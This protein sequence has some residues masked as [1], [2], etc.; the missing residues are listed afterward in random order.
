MT[1]AQPGA[2]ARELGEDAIIEIFSTLGSGAPV[3]PEVL[4][5]NGDDAA[6]WAVATGEAVVATTDTLVEGV[7]F[8][9][10]FSAGAAR[11]A[12][13]KL[14]AVNLSDLAAM[15]ARP[16]YALI[17]VCA[18]ER[19]ETRTLEAIA[20][21]IGEAACAQGVSVLGGNTTRTAGPL[22]LTATLIGG[23]DPRTLLRRGGSRPG[24]LLWTTGVLGDA[25]GGLAV[26][27]RG[28]TAFRP[29]ER[30]AAAALLT[31]LLEPRAQVEAGLALAGSG[32]VHAAADISDGLGRDVRRL[33][34]VDRLGARIEVDRLP[35]SDALRR[36][37]GPPLG[38]RAVDLALSGGE[39][40]ELLF[41][42][43]P[44]DEPRIRAACARAGTPVHPIGRVIAQ[45]TFVAVAGPDPEQILPLPAGFEH[46]R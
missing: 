3:G 15:G 38:T 11:S 42:A 35:L 43:D 5:P 30:A 12:G 14:I 18:P 22:V 19:V 40:Y 2:T 31:A 8:D 39:D 25:R 24:D 37:D 27:R 44:A 16:R 4:V 13:K 36:L 23:A 20:A 7:H 10:A 1:T 46:F 26:A 9:L 6:A 29:E 32:A 45:P 17:S 34:A 21:G 28:L 33:L 41:T